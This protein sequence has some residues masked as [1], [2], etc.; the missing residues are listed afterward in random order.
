MHGIIDLKLRQIQNNAMK[1]S[2]KLKFF[3]LNLVA[4]VIVVVVIGI[5]VLFQ[6]DSYTHHGESIAVP[7]FYDMTPPEAEALAKHHNLRIKVV[8]SL[9]DDHAKP[10]AVVEQYPASG[11]RVNPAD[12]QCAKSGKDCI[13][14]S[15][16][17]CIPSNF[18]NTGKPGIQDRTYRIRGIRI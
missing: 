9:Y 14:Q 5:V 13:S 2:A 11:S 6:L 10:G 7:Q 4:A 15:E 16:K 3:L 12:D 18:T 17:F 8:D 1:I